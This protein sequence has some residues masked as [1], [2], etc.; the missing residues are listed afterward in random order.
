MSFDV[1]MGKIN[2]GGAETQRRSQKSDFR[3][4]IS[5]DRR[6]EGGPVGGG[7]WAVRRAGK[8]RGRVDE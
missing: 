2:H 8:G 3:F 5:E 6:K 1:K 4:E 7:E